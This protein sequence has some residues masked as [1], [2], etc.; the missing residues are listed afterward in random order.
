MRGDQLKIGLALAAIFAICLGVVAATASDDPTAKP[1]DG[2]GQESAGLVGLADAPGGGKGGGNVESTAGIVGGSPVT[3]DQFPWQVAIAA[4]PKINPADAFQRQGCGGTLLTPTVV[5]TAAHCVANAKGRLRAPPSN[6]SVISGRTTLTSNEG[7]ETVISDY[8]YFVDGQNRQLYDPRNNAWDVVLMI[9]PEPALGTPI[10]IAGPDEL[11][12]WAPGTP[13]LV[14]GWGSV[15]G[16]SG[17]F[18]E[19]LLAAT[20][21]IFSDRFCDRVVPGVDETSVCAGVRSGARDTCA[22]DSGGPLVVTT[23]EGER[24]LVGATSYGPDPCGQPGQPGVYTRVADEPIRSSVQAAVQQ[25]AGVD[26]IGS[27]ATPAQ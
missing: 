24:R 18:P 22:G 12:T 23:A 20:I 25:I 16:G 8:Q 21:D 15:Q 26:V 6:F 11:A 13:A 17:P 5:L 14:S 7:I 19:N 10:K 4:S 1:D 9:L 3:I 27:G 2:G